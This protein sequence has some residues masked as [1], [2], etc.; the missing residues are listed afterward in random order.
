MLKSIAIAVLLQA[1]LLS[2]ARAQ[3]K[4]ETIS[5]TSRTKSIKGFARDFWFAP[6]EL[7]DLQGNYKYY[8]MYVSSL[9]AAR[10]HVQVGEVK[11]MDYTIQPQEVLVYTI[12]LMWELT[13]S[14]T[15][16]DKAI[17]VWTDDADLTVSVL[18]RQPAAS[19]AMMVLPTSAWGKE[20]VLA[21][22]ASFAYLPGYE[23]PSE[24]T[25]VANTDSTIIT[26][27]PSTDLRD[28]FSV[29]VAFPRHVPFTI[30]LQKGQAVQYQASAANGNMED[31][32]VTGTII[33]SNK[34]IGVAAGVMCANVPAENPYCDHLCEMLLPTSLWGK[35]Y[36]T[37]P[38]F[39]R[40][41]GDGI[42]VIAKEDNTT[43]KRTSAS[44]TT[45]HCVLNRFQSYM[46]HD[47]DE[48]SIFVGDRPFMLVQY[49]NGTD[50]PDAGSNQGIGDPAMVVVPPSSLFERDVLF[51]IPKI[52]TSESQYTN[53][54]N[55]I[56][57]KNA[58]ATTRLDGTAALD[59]LSPLFLPGSDYLLYRI[60][61]IQPGVHRLTSD[62]VAG[63]YVYGYGKADAYALPGPMGK[64]ANDTSD[65]TAPIVTASS[66]SCYTLDVNV[67][68]KEW[69]AIGQLQF[70][71]DSV[72]NATVSTI[73]ISG[74]N[75]EKVEYR[76]SITD[77]SR[78]AF[79]RV[80][81]ADM[82]GNL[83]TL[84]HTYVPD[85][86]TV[87]QGPIEVRVP[88]NSDK[89]FAIPIS[90]GASTPLNNITVR[91]QEGTRFG[92]LSF[93]HSLA[94]GATDSIRFRASQHEVAVNIDTLIIIAN[95]W[96]RKI[97]LR[98]S[99]TP[100]TDWIVRDTAID[101]GDV[102]VGSQA[103]R[104]AKILNVGTEPFTVDS[105]VVS[106]GEGFWVVP[107]AFPMGL[108]MTDSMEVTFRFGPL[109]TAKVEG[110]ANIYTSLGVKS[111]HLSGQGKNPAAV[112]DRKRDGSLSIYPNPATNAL[113]IKLSERY[114]ADALAIR[115]ID[116]LGIERLKFMADKNAL[117]RELDIRALS[118]G[119]YTLELVLRDGSTLHQKFTV[120][121]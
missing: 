116:A 23:L 17:H 102:E 89:E 18:S 51:E 28:G 105:I 120:S 39:Q 54:A 33:Q 64:F 114:K 31:Y 27:V 2:G 50:Y 77:S 76:V 74:A 100:F 52:R 107:V 81:V 79:A 65:V 99:P 55:L 83:R 91:L 26:I 43:I 58:I 61:G 46:R 22:F 15:I 13:E 80:I 69:N 97:G 106:K 70:S 73:F 1:A 90:S 93:P 41:G 119:G 21:A 86:P 84:T 32:D 118:N 109:G 87:P 88:L 67:L 30:Q 20:Y 113:R 11:A 115:I 57:H 60:K 45:T 29:D 4:I 3:G 35:Q 71:K 9:Q 25:I 44:G 103:S 37:A 82:A 42:L 10:I 117:D 8:Q 112:S 78:A 56:I 47:I 121:R 96:T 53:F 94:A 95:C 111:V 108:S 66:Q 12:P 48:A 85:L 104:N 49:I 5:E 98:G 38:F 101:F 6:V 72:N 19:D 92:L 16:E 59:T 36:Y 110:L 68:D 24:F 7:Y 75:R 34:I 62:S 40:K 63:A 14:H